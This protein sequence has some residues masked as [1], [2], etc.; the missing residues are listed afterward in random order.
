MNL[1]KET[2]HANPS[3][4]GMVLKEVLNL[5]EEDLNDL[6]DLLSETSFS[7]IIKL[8]SITSDRLK[9]LDGISL[10]L[11]DHE[12]KKKVRE[13]S[14]LHKVLVDNLWILGEDYLYGTDDQTLKNVLKQ[15]IKILGRESNEIHDESKLTDIPDIFIYK[16]ISPMME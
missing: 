12:L 16:N 14:M 5:K 6:V 7:N 8:S 13:R 1:L 9:I 4:V 3:N 10:L 11:F 15:H 2:L